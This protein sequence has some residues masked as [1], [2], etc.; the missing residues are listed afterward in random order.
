LSA[1]NQFPSQDRTTMSYLATLAGSSQ[2]LMAVGKVA[3][4]LSAGA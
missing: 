3:A 1:E 2:K 4:P